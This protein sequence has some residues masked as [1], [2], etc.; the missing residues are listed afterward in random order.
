MN[1]SCDWDRCKGREP[2]VRLPMRRFS[3]PRRFALRGGCDRE[4]PPS[5]NRFRRRRAP[6]S[7]RDVLERFRAK[8]VPVRVK[9]TRQNKRLEPPF[10]F[11]RNGKSSR[12]R[13]RFSPNSS[14]FRAA[15]YLGGG[16]S[17]WQE[18]SVARGLAPLVYPSP[19][20]LDPRSGRSGAIAMRRR[21]GLAKIAQSE[22]VDG[23]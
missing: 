15:G 8:W 10:R 12:A 9:K 4:R 19:W 17:W 18:V 2:G 3:C 20:G 11:N 7:R 5:V 6:F 21:V 1:L 23:A 16:V 14:R 13:C 22:I